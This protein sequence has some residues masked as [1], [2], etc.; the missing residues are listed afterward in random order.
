MIGLV[1]ADNKIILNNYNLSIFDV[2]S[3][4]MNYSFFKMVG[5]LVGLLVYIGP[6]ICWI[7][8][9][10]TIC[11]IISLFNSLNFY[12]DKHEKLD[13]GDTQTTQL[14]MVKLLIIL[15][16]VIFAIL[17]GFIY[18]GL[19][20]SNFFQNGLYKLVITFILIIFFIV[21]Y[22]TVNFTVNFTWTWY[23]IFI[24]VIIL[25]ITLLRF[26]KLF[27]E[28]YN[29]KID[30]PKCIINFG[31]AL[32]FIILFS[33]F[34]WFLILYIYENNIQY[35][36][37]LIPIIIWFIYLYF[38]VFKS[39]YTSN[40]VYLYGIFVTLLYVISGL[41]IYYATLASGLI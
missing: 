12:N 41:S 19:L 35:I 32:E 31:V 10:I 27:Y 37:I 15:S 3:N 33:S 11:L 34:I 36:Y 4:D 2:F 14:N 40:N 22:F 8:V 20:T 21:Y 16:I 24:F 25:V 13:L 38:I 18:C 26:L 39:E 29:D 1:M 7:M 5:I 17:Y 30:I 6:I 9:F 23:I 28:R